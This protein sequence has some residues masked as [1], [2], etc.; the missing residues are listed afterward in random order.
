MLYWYWMQVL[1]SPIKKI[2]N[3][4]EPWGDHQNEQFHLQATVFS[5]VIWCR[6][7]KRLL[8]TCQT[9]PPTCDVRTHQSAVSQCGIFCCKSKKNSVGIGR[10]LTCHGHWIKNLNVYPRW[11]SLWLCLF[12]FRT[13]LWSS[14]IL[15]CG[16]ILQLIDPRTGKASHHTLHCLHNLTSELSEV[17]P[18]K[19]TVKWDFQRWNCSSNT[20]LNMMVFFGCLGV[21]L[22]GISVDPLMIDINL[23]WICFS[24]SSKTSTLW[25]AQ[26]PIKNGTKLRSRIRFQIRTC[27]VSQYIIWNQKITRSTRKMVWQSSF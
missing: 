14:A 9:R 17:I 24:N 7:L 10:R 18:K 2:P 25:K 16:H 1:A 3:T 26:T 5:S 6:P 23:H 8:M 15:V 20:W 13:L 11:R 21:R 12:T 19:K 4:T 27:S 22:L